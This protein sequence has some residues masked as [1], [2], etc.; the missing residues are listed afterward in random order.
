M[1]ARNRGLLLPGGAYDS[2]RASRL[3]L[4]ELRDGLIGPVS[5]EGSEDPSSGWEIIQ[6][7]Q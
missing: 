6:E 2:E 7:E 4:K 3:F 5:L 1:I